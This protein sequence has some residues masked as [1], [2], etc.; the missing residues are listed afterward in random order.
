[1]RLH[2]VCAQAAAL[3]LGTLAGCTGQ[4]G[5]MSGGPGSGRG[6]AG[7]GGDGAAAHSIDLTGSPQYYRVVR[8]TN[9]QWARAVQD[10]L[11]LPAPSGLEQSFQAA[12]TGTT[13][14]SN[15]ELVL[16]VNQR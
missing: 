14:F 10:I 4:I 3:A 8:L 1:M 11:N 6:G 9:A 13:A 2:R 5:D 12:V 15:N 16:E 7:T